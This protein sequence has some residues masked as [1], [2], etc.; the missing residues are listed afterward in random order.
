MLVDRECGDK[1][2]VPEQPEGRATEATGEEIMGDGRE[3]GVEIQ[4]VEQRQASNRR[5]ERDGQRSE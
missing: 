3:L 4:R 5:R 2:L 1:A